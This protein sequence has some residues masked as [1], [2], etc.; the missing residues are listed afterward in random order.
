MGGGVVRFAADP[1]P[2]HGRQDTPDGSITYFRSVEAV[3][4]CIRI[5]P[6]RDG[7]SL[8]RSIRTFTHFGGFIHAGVGLRFWTFPFFSQFPFCLAQIRESIPGPSPHSLTLHVP[9]PTLPYRLRF[10]RLSI[11]AVC[12]VCSPGARLHV[13]HPGFCVVV[14]G[15]SP[16]GLYP[17]VLRIRSSPGSNCFLAYCT[18]IHF[19]PTLF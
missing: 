2:E 13:R 11:Q 9:S 8:P 16:P 14:P 17:R 4:S 7:Q 5:L 10:R 1:H 6:C 12:R 15:S 18:H 3:R 19:F